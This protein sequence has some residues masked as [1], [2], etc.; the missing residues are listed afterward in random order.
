MYFAYHNTF[1]YRAT[2]CITMQTFGNWL[3]SMIFC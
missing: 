3:I 2:A 1:Y